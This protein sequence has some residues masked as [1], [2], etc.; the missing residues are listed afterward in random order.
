M[1][2]PCPACGTQHIDV[3]DLP[4]PC[5]FKAAPAPCAAHPALWTNPP[6]KSHKCAFCGLIWRP[7][8]VPTTGVASIKTRGKAD[9]WPLL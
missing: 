8:D 3:A 9:T 5:C 1:I 6:H 2:L 4:R 7:A